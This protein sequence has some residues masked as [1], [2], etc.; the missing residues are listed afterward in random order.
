MGKACKRRHIHSLW[1][2][3]LYEVV[4]NNYNENKIG[5]KHS[6]NID[7]QQRLYKNVEL[8]HVTRRLRFQ[9]INLKSITRICS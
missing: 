5:Q 9:V 7:L 8:A 1:I 2:V 4:D 6:G 3:Y